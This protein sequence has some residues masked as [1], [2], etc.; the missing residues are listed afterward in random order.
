MRELKKESISVTKDKLKIMLVGNPNVGKSAIFS[1]LTGKYVTISNYPGTTV[2]VM[3][4]EYSDTNFQAVIIDTP[5]INSLFAFSEDEVVT[6]DMLVQMSPDIIVQVGDMKNL[7]KTLSLTLSLTYFNTPMVLVLNM[8]DEARAL[9][10]SVNCKKLSSLLGIPVVSTVAV[11]GHGISSLRTAILNSRFSYIEDKF[12]KENKELFTKVRAFLPSDVKA[13]NFLSLL[14]LAGEYDIPVCLLK[15]Y[16]RCKNFELALSIELQKEIDS[17]HITLES[18]LKYWLTGAGEL[19]EQCSKVNKVKK[20]LL[21]EKL[22]RLFMEPL[23]GFPVFLI[24]LALMYFIV[25]EFAAGT[26]VDFLESVVF[27]KYLI[28][29][30][31][32]IFVFFTGKTGFFYDFFFGEFGLI[33]MGLTYAIAIVFPI[34]SFFFIFLGFLEDSGYLPRLAAMSNRFLKLFGISGRAVLPMVLGTCCTTMAIMTTRILDSRKE[35]ILV[36]LLLALAIPCSAQLGI[37]LGVLSKISVLAM[38][39]FFVLIFFQA[40]TVSF[41]ADRL[42]KGKKIAFISELP[43][44]R[45][46]GWRNLFLKTYFRISWFLKEAM[47]LFFLGTLTLFLLDK[48]HLLKVF[49]NYLSPIVKNGMGLPE[50]TSII[51]IMGFFRRDYGAAGLMKMF[52]NGLIT[53][54]QAFI[55]LMVVTLFI[56]CVA[57]LYIMIKERGLKISIY[58]SSFVIIY[59]FLAGIALNFIFKTTGINLGG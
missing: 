33:S 15:S 54:N 40:I 17:K 57:S 41:I 47:P 21:S 19:V 18:I 22:G 10:I 32:R 30:L 37:I 16:S 49:S 56:P 2:E 59:A 58:I 53:A 36:T 31:E 5:G 8:A 43:P 55:A 42:L 38:S 1:A 26:V 24:V 11:E 13:K 29:F 52:D 48:L 28:P 14:V 20:T 39:V 25:G 12:L 27:G 51:F 44:I 6:R 34:V 23:T 46:P 4:G 50:R 3:Q 45:I 9:G 35:R 7:E